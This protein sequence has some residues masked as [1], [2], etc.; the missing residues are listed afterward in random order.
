MLSLQTPQ[1]VTTIS[2]SKMPSRGEREGSKRTGSWTISY[3]HTSKPTEVWRGGRAVKST[4]CSDRPGFSSQHR[5]SSSR[6]PITPV[7]GNPIPSS[8]LSDFMYTCDNVVHLHT[9]IKWAKILWCKKTNTDL[10]IPPKTQR[11]FEKGIQR[12][13]ATQISLLRR[14]LCVCASPIIL[15]FQDQKDTASCW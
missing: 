3:T 15:P 6:L 1:W 4:C 13:T 5:H 12:S 14:L 2:N 11:G 8:D 7:P 10:E 9:H